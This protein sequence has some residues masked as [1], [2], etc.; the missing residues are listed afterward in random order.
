MSIHRAIAAPCFQECLAFHNAMFQARRNQHQQWQMCFTWASGGPCAPRCCSFKSQLIPLPSATHVLQ[1][2]FRGALHITSRFD[3]KQSR[4]LPSSAYVL[5]VLLRGCLAIFIAVSLNTE[6]NRCHA[7]TVCHQSFFRSCFQFTWR[8][9]Q[10]PIDTISFHRTR[11][12]PELKECV[13]FRV[14]VSSDAN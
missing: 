10:K 9:A 12:S 6:W 1:F 7:S 11:A 5:L 3:L 13:A 8:C 4:Q 2:G 14:A